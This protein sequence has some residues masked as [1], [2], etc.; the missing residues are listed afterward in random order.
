MIKL[1]ITPGNK[2][3]GMKTGFGA[4]TSFGNGK[5]SKYADI[6]D[7]G[8]PG[9]P[10]TRGLRDIGELEDLEKTGELPI[11]VQRAFFESCKSG[12]GKE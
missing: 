9:R 11:G 12:T 3:V 7:A 8:R 1:T 6:L 2:S 10:P 5:L 4:V